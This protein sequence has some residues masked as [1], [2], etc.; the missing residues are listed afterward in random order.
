MSR[1]M[2]F[3]VVRSNSL[4]YRSTSRLLRYIVA[5]TA[6]VKI[7]PKKNA[8]LQNCPKIAVFQNCPKNAAFQNCPKNAYF[9]ICPKIAVFQNC[10]K[11]CGSTNN[12]DA[13]QTGLRSRSMAAHFGQ[14]RILGRPKTNEPASALTQR[15]T[16]AVSALKTDLRYYRVMN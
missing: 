15:A 2:S 14:L 9:N 1:S 3:F 8:A 6:D 5:G 11:N 16:E 12:Q 7:C 13:F 4:T 10:S